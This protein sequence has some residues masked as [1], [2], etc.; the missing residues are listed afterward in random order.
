MFPGRT[1]PLDG[2][3]DGQGYGLY[4]TIAGGQMEPQAVSQPNGV[5]G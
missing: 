4:F 5:T 1:V 2:F 3:H